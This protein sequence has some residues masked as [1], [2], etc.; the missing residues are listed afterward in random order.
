VTLQQRLEAMFDGKGEKE[1]TRT[2]P[3]NDDYRDV[4]PDYKMQRDLYGSRSY[5]QKSKDP[6]YHISPREQRDLYERFGRSEG[7]RNIFEDDYPAPP[8]PDEPKRKKR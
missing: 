6:G 4:A 2:R 7:T 3:R 5:G 1:K 8:S